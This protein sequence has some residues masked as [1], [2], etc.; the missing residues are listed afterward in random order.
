MVPGP[1]SWL[2]YVRIAFTCIHGWLNREDDD[3]RD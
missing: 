3:A 2:L 1:A